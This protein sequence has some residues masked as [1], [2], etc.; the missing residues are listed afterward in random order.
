TCWSNGW[1]K[2]KCQDSNSTRFLSRDT[3]MSRFR[4]M[5]TMLA[6]HW[7]EVLRA[8]GPGALRAGN[9]IFSAAL[10]TLW[11]LGQTRGQAVMA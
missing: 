10:V 8:D 9:P 5:L 3:E 4:L 7:T 11:S 2:R 1:Q 6:T